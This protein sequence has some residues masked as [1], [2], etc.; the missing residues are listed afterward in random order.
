MSN[1]KFI[2]IIQDKNLKKKLPESSDRRRLRLEL[3]EIFGYRSINR[4]V[5]LRRRAASGTEPTASQLK[6]MQKVFAK[7]GIGKDEI[8]NKEKKSEQPLK[9]QKSYAT[10][11]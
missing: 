8:F 10:N 1:Y 3:C 6:A 7:Y 9:K 2:N 11:D 5:V 4:I